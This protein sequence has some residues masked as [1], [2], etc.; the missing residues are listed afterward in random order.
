MASLKQI[1]ANQANAKKST[2]PKSKSG[3]K[4]VGHNALKHGLARDPQ[5]TETQQA[6]KKLL[7]Q[8]LCHYGGEHCREKAEL[9]AHFQVLLN[10]IN[11]LERDCYNFRIQS[12]DDFT[13]HITRCYHPY[14]MTGIE[15]LNM[16]KKHRKL[17]RY[18]QS[19]QLRRNQ[20]LATFE[21]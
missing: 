5:L 14:E 21:D 4:R 8:R 12:T 13:H 20:V 18:R 10:Y 2:G 19:L 17:Q 15:V 16:M 11:T 1:L 9:L 7:V 3:R 6:Q